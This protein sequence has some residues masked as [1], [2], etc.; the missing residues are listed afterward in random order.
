VNSPPLRVCHKSVGRRLTGVL[1]LHKWFSLHDHMQG[2]ACRWKFGLKS[3]RTGL[4]RPCVCNNYWVSPVIS[5]REYFSHWAAD[6]R[7]CHQ[8]VCANLNWMQLATDNEKGRQIPDRLRADMEWN[9]NLVAC[10]RSLDHTVLRDC[11]LTQELST[12]FFRLESCPS[13]LHPSLSGQYGQ[14]F[15]L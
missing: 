4:H 11:G 12:R 13:R 10:P 1:V 7:Y 15:C 5:H 3:R 6:V 8:E 9:A 2:L 14:G